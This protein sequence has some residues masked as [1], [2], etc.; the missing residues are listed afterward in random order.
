[1]RL[2]QRIE[3]AGI[4]I[5]TRCIYDERVPSIS[6]N[7]EGVCCYCEQIDK[8]KSEY[9]TGTAKGELLFGGILERI[10]SKGKGRKYDCIIG[11]SGG[12]DSSYL[13]HLAKTEWGLRPLA[14]HYDNT[15][16]TAIAST[17]MSKL[18]KALEID[19]HSYVMPNKEADDIFRSFFIAGVPEIDASTDL[20]FSYVLRMAAKKF[21]INYILEGHTFMEEGI[22]PLGK[23]Y[24]DGR[25]IKAIHSKY[26]KQRLRKYPLMTFGR[27]LY[28][29]IFTKVEFIRPYWYIK[30]RKDD[31]K[32]LLAE[33]YGWRYYGGHHLENRMT[34]FFQS[35][36]L[37]KKFN[38]DM[39]NNT[40]SAQVRNGYISRGEAW[41]E[42]NTEPFSE[43][44]LEDYFCR[45]LGF[46]GDEYEEL[47]KQQPKSWKEFPTYK[48]RFEK[49]APVF[50]ILARHNRVT[51]SFYLK[52]CRKE[53]P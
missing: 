43:D 25:Y 42:Y 8:L 12:T 44:F 37:P 35:T 9:G 39:R 6:F 16:N 19:L 50:K 15:W 28:S 38:C 17:N 33:L 48:R 51:H 46:S 10:R 45:R 23:N 3:E 13:M 22:T 52:Y 11:I 20:A 27:F 31:A 1:M 41:R 29:A 14:V 47:M 21:N 32:K 2:N 26:G 34:A 36:L 24:F 4:V 18:L 40:L 30:Y 53:A 7:G 5:C 49:W